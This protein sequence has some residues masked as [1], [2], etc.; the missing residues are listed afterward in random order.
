MSLRHNTRIV[1]K[2]GSALIAPGNDGC[3]AKY[4]KNIAQFIQN[5][6]QQGQQVILVS[7]GSVAAGRQ[8]FDV[9]SPTKALKK[10]MAA[11]GQNDMMAI[12]AKLLDM[13]LAQILLT[14]ADLCNRERYVSIKDTIESLLEHNVLPVINENDTM[15]SEELKVG[16]NDNLA[17]MAAAAIDADTLIMCTDVN[18]LYD[19]NPH[20]Y[21][22]AQLIQQVNEITSK[23]YSMAGGAVSATGTGGMLT[24]IQAA[25]KA[26]AQGI[27][28]LIINGFENASFE[29]LLAGKNPGTHFLANIEP[30]SP[31]IHWMTHT[32]KE[33]GEVIINDTTTTH[34]ASDEDMLTSGNILEVKGQFSAGD[35][36]LV[37]TDD[38]TKVAK[39]KTNYSS[40]LLNYIAQEQDDE[41]TSQ[42]YFAQNDSIISKEHLTVLENE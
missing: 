3:S 4:L 1:V 7:S 28:T 6:R 35:T 17:A 25:E 34:F 11:A 39:A 14:H 13:P 33:R 2:V 38:G 41:N 12:W 20:Q 26:T 10:A 23:I 24:K 32:V 8:W 27:D 36:I 30:L 42:S 21:D 9:D 5:C 40:C 18:G 19:K 15:T 16:D 37:S 22:N 29:Q 31:A